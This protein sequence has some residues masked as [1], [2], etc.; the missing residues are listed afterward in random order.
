MDEACPE[1]K[2]VMEVL[3][4]DLEESRH[5]KSEGVVAG[6]EWWVVQPKKTLDQFRRT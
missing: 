6:L 4:L 1:V 5:R 2:P 3:N